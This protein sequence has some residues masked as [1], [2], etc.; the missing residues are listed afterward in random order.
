MR[1][2]PLPKEPPPSAADSGGPRRRPGRFLHGEEHV[3]QDLLAVEIG[4]VRL[5]EEAMRLFPHLQ[6]TIKAGRAGAGQPQAFTDKVSDN[7]RGSVVRMNSSLENSSI[8]GR[9]T[10]KNSQTERSERSPTRYTPTC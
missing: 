5:A 6:P 7:F 4:G 10:P 3:Q 8:L 2:I 9:R 1:P